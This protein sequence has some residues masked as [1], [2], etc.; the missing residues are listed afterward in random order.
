VKI[1]A[2]YERWENCVDEMRPIWRHHWN[3]LGLDRGV[4]KQDMDEERYKNMQSSGVLH[5][6]TVR[7]DGKLVGYCICFVVPHMHYKSA[8]EMALAD[9]YYILPAYRVGGA[10]VKMFKEV[11]RTLRN[12]GVTRGHMSC[13]VHQD[14][15]ALF[16]RLG[17]EFTDKTFSKLFK[18]N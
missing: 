3:E 7:A 5:I 13:K 15:Q 10:G 16:E 1:M 6:I 2:Q 4:I 17:W 9:M 8:G 12:R 18:G 11:E 14:H